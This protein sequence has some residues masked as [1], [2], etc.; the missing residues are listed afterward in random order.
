MANGTDK[1]NK[2]AIETIETIETDGAVKRLGE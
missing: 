1:A 2:M